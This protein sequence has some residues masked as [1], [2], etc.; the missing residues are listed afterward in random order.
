MM[1]SKIWLLIVLSLFQST[2]VK[3]GTELLGFT[4]NQ[5]P[6]DVVAQLGPPEG[7]DDS[8]PN[9]VSWLFKGNARD[10]RD[11]AYIVCFRRDDNRLVSVTRTFEKD[12][13]VDHLFP[14]GS[15]TVHNWP[16]DDNPQFSVRVRTLSDG[17]LLL[18]MGSGQAGK[19]CGQLVLIDREMLPFF[20][21][22]I[23]KPEPPKTL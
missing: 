15:F 13:I 5:T 6:S 4:L 9:Y 18:A 1:V 20:F 22:W 3:P 23:T 12:E 14:D 8:L 2:T 17:R 16:S 7:V 19:P 21:P 10:E 11:Y